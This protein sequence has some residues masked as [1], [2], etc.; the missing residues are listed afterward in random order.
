MYIEQGLQKDK[1]IKTSGTWGDSEKI[2]TINKKKCSK[3]WRKYPKGKKIR[4]GSLDFW[5]WCCH[6]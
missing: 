4:G 6:L 2:S 1:N 5:D 3:N